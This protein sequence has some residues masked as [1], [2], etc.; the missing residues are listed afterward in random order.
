LNGLSD[1]LRPW[2]VAPVGND[3]QPPDLTLR[4]TGEDLLDMFI[5]RFHPST[6]YFLRYQLASFLVILISE[7]FFTT[8]TVVFIFSTN[9]TIGPRPF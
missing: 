2:A 3:L 1:D 7:D 5:W 4:K 8:S 9:L 6:T